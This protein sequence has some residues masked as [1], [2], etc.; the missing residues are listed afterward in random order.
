MGAPSGQNAPAGHGA[1][2]KPP[3]AAT[4]L[5]PG[6]HTLLL[7]LAVGQAGQAE[8]PAAGAKVPVGQREQ[9][10]APVADET[11]LRNSKMLQNDKPTTTAAVK[12][13]DDAMK[14]TSTKNIKTL[15]GWA[16]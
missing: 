3:T 2:K 10:V 1:H 14:N 8:A 15:P 9:A 16:R 7:L 13:S 12:N 4:T 11:K 6:A 5:A